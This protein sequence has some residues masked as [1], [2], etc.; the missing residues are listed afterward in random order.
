M[1][2]NENWK[3]LTLIYLFIL[4]FLHQDSKQGN[5]FLVSSLR[6][7]FSSLKEAIIDFNN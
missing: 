4:I 7:D 6:T 5:F 2:D 1:E 3:L